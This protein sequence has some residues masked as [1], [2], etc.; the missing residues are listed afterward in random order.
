MF[1][2][3]LNIILLLINDGYAVKNQIQ[4]TETIFSVALLSA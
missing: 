4:E 3:Y 2:V 1:F